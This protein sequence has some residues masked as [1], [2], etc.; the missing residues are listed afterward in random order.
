[1]NEQNVEIC[2]DIISGL[3]T[4]NI[5]LSLETDHIA[6]T[7]NTNNLLCI[8]VFQVFGQCLLYAIEKAI[9]KDRF[10]QEDYDAWMMFYHWIGGCIVKG[11]VTESSR[12]T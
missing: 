2:A 11:I 8:N 6:T 5:Q 1:M 10:S 9:G 4:L 7:G 12:K 3:F